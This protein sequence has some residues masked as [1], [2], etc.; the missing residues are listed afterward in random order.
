MEKESLIT[1][2]LRALRRVA[3]TAAAK[4]GRTPG[5]AAAS[6]AWKLALRWGRVKSE[7]GS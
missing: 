4:S 7:V 5:L 6:T 1:G 2:D 3:E